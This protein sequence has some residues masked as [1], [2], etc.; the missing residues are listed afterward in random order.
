MRH[1]YNAKLTYLCFILFAILSNVRAHAQ[2]D[3]YMV[4]GSSLDLNNILSTMPLSNKN[5]KIGVGKRKNKL[6]AELLYD[7]FWQEN[8][9]ILITSKFIGLNGYYDCFNINNITIYLTAGVAFH[10]KIKYTYEQEKWA[11]SFETAPV[12]CATY[13]IGCHIQLKENLKVAGE[14]KSFVFDNNNLLYLSLGLI[15]D[16]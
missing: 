7:Q 16:L 3:I 12:Q 6:R 8:S 4:I 15:I 2:D 11:K 1:T 14:F 5:I 9:N 13:G 10:Y